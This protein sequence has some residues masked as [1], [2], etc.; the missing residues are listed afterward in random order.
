MNNGYFFRLNKNLS[1][2]DAGIVIYDYIDLPAYFESSKT[3]LMSPKYP[4]S[5]SIRSDAVEFRVHYSVFRNNDDVQPNY[6]NSINEI[7]PIFDEKNTFARAKTKVNIAHMEEVILELPFT[8]S[9]KQS[10]HQTIKNIYST[11][12]PQSESAQLGGGGRFLKELIRERYPY[13]TKQKTHTENRIREQ[14]YESK[15]KSSNGILSYASLKI[16]GFVDKNGQKTFDIYDESEQITGFLRKLMLDFMFDLTHSDIFQNSSDYSSMYHGLMSDYYFSALYHKCEYYY[17]RHL[18]QDYYK[19]NGSDTNNNNITLPTLYLERL[20]ESEKNWVNDILSPK[21]DQL[22]DHTNPIDTHDNNEKNAS[23]LSRIWHFCTRNRYRLKAYPSWFAEPEVEMRRIHTIL[24]EYNPD[25]IIRKQI[26]NK[27]KNE[28]DNELSNYIDTNR[29]IRNE[30]SKWYLKRYDFHDLFDL[31]ISRAFNYVF[32]LC[33]L[34]MICLLVLTQLQ[35]TQLL[36]WTIIIL[37][38]SVSALFCF[39]KKR[40]REYWR[41]HITLSF[42]AHHLLLPRLVASIATAW[43][44]LSLGFDLF[45][46]FFDSK[47]SVFTIVFVTIII[48]LF[49]QYNI[50]SITPALNRWKKMTRSL[51]LLMISFLISFSIGIVM[52]NFIGQNYLERGGAIGDFY[53]Q[54]VFTEQDYANNPQ[55]Y[56]NKIKAGRFYIYHNQDIYAKTA[57]GKSIRDSLNNVTLDSLKNESLITFKRLQ[58]ELVNV[59]HIKYKNARFTGIEHNHPIAKRTSGF[60]IPFTNLDIPIFTT[61]FELRDFTITFAFFAMFMGI[62]IQLII[63]GDSKQMTEL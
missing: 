18:I 22:F 24:K 3:N 12:F 50:N 19:D 21:S 53:T 39:S 11:H 49:V 15:R 61:I 31:H 51:E 41:N 62:F 2:P 33:L 44:T 57:L 23:L 55:E 20:I 54:Y 14:L 47:P 16:M 40:N 4:I 63:F 34:G 6:F 35:I 58:N 56:E 59:Y 17:N 7:K 52:V 26:K 36:G 5:A 10:L 30:S 13:S 8:D 25:N 60:H 29:R 9:H 1:R 27:Q 38:A 45:N 32:F 46:S 42:K 28:I 37:I 43:I 48:F